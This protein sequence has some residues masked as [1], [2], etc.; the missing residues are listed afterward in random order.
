MITNTEKIIAL[1]CRVSTDIQREKE[2]ISTQVSR[3]TEYA[4]EHH[5]NYKIYKDNGY[6][7][8][9]VN[10]PA[11][12]QLIQDIKE[13]KINSVVVTALD[14]ISRSVKNLI[15]LLELF[16]SH[17]VSFKSL[18]Q[19]LDTSS[20]IG[21]AFLNLLG[22]F[23]ELERGMTAERVRESMRNKAKTEGR[24]LGGV[25]PYGYKNEN[26][27]LVIVTEE[28][29]VVKIIFN[30]YLELESLRGVTHFLNSTERK[31]R[32]GYSWASASISRI[33]TNPTYIGKTWYGKRQ[34][35]TL[36]GKLK[37]APK[38]E[39]IITDGEHK[40]IIDKSTFEKVGEILKRQYVKPRRKLSEFLLSGL[41]RCG[42]CNGAMSGYSQ[43]K[44]GKLYAYYKCHHHGSKG[45]AVCKGETITKDTLEKIVTDKILIMVENNK[46][47][48]DMKKALDVFNK[49]IDNEERPLSEEKKQLENRN[50]IIRQKKR[51]LLEAIE[52]KT[53]DKETYKNRISELE[54]EFEK[55]QNRL[56]QIETKLNDL[57][58]DQVSFETV[59]ESLNDFKKSFKKLSY[60]GKKELLWQIVS[61]IV[62][63]DSQ[64]DIDL[65]FLPSLFSSSICSH[66]DNPAV[67]N[68]NFCPLV[69]TFDI[70][71]NPLD[72]SP[73]YPQN[74]RTLGQRI[75]KARMDS[76]LMIKEL[77]AQ[78]GV[79]EDTVINWE[80]RGI[81]PAGRNLDK[82]QDFLKN[83]C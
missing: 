25:L 24:W 33:L 10:R 9:D 51:N 32:K 19:P 36:T 30:K 50:L 34:S 43:V 15:D 14:R 26:K 79:T 4:K 18:T 39:W 35:S 28:A 70:E 76:G 3:L 48:V 37:S 78:I 45:S 27:K 5:L 80:I 17:S 49:K 47:K 8:K 72:F 21:R 63:K 82:V 60:V 7:A 44:D 54:T 6:S 20:A 68:T 40:P 59:Y 65:F 13:D 71:V 62:V 83:P 64:I 55:N 73:K 67:Q 69:Y 11:L 52:D 12:K 57:G 29:R 42:K 81:N 46:F 1:Y 31:T 23:A 2:S 61:K 16:E 56:Y 38:E 41:V 66:T 53:I 75:R 77:A 58:I 74:P 22:I